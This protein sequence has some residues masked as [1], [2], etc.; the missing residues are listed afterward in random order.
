MVKEIVTSSVITALVPIIQ[1]NGKGTKKDKEMVKDIVT[2]S[3][4]TALVP[5]IKKTEKGTKTT[6]R[7]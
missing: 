3:V 2:S 5:I 4:V 1:K 6:W 7:L